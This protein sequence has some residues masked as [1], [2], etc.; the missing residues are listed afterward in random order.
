MAIPALAN[1]NQVSKGRPALALALATAI[2]VPLTTPALAAS[3]ATLTALSFS[4][5]SPRW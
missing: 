3:L 2:T 5:V 1:V 4:V